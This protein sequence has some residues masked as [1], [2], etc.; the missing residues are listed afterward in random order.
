[1]RMSGGLRTILRRSSAVVSPVRMAVRTSGTS[2]PAAAA[3][4]PMPASGPRRLRST[5][6][7]SALSGD[8]YSTRTPLAQRSPASWA[9]AFSAMSRSMAKRKAA[10]VLPEPVGAMTSALSP[11][12]MACHASACTG[13]G[14][15]KARA[16]HSRTGAENSIRASPPA[17]GPPAFA[18]RFPIGRLPRRPPSPARARRP[19]SSPSIIGEAAP[20]PRGGGQSGARAPTRVFSPFPSPPAEQAGMMAAARRNGAKEGSCEAARWRG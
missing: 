11:R 15:S 3:A 7:P 17:A 10:S 1:M 14:A 5:S 13:V 16:N 19:D 18:P 8:T 2:S 6:A 12:A 9:A 20:R 4:A